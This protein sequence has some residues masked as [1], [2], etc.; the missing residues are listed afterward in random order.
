MARIL[1]QGH[2]E[3]RAAK[4]SATCRNPLETFLPGASVHPKDSARASDP[5]S[6]LTA[7]WLI[8]MA[9]V[10]GATFG[11]SSSQAAMESYTTAEQDA[12]AANGA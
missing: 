2:A 8:I 5:A 9:S 4:Q 6:A 7:N 1:S 3:A 10:A 12:K 11:S